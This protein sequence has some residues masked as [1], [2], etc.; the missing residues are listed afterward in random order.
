MATRIPLTLDDERR[1]LCA[2]RSWKLRNRCLIEF[3]LRTGFRA[4]E[5]GSLTIGQVWDGTQVRDEVT[6]ARCHLKGGRGVRRRAVRSRTVPLAPAA[7][8][9]LLDYLAS[10]LRHQDGILAPHEPLFKSTQNSGGIGRWMINALVKRAC[11]RPAF[12][13]T[14][15]TGATRSESRSPTGSTRRPGVT[16]ILRV[17]LSVTGTLRLPNATLRCPMIRCATRSSSS[18]PERKPFL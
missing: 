15:V 8:A 4:S 18:R 7:K 16:S 11:A 12:R 1:V 2:I 9:I 14:A 6:V 13:K 5:I 17:R 3:G 10:C